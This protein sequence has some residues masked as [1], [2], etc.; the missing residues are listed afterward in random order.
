MYYKDPF[1]RIKKDHVGPVADLEVVK[2]KNAEGN[3]GENGEE[4]EKGGEEE[5][6]EATEEEVEEEEIPV[7]PKPRKSKHVTSKPGRKGKA[8]VIYSK[9]PKKKQK[10]PKIDDVSKHKKASR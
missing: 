4:R 6:E 7:I 5:I 10:L 3:E 1:L 2:K 9:N 8:M